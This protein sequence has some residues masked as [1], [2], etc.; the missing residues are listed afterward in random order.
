MKT[1]WI[2]PSLIAAGAVAALA[3]CAA[4]KPA[5]MSWVGAARGVATS[6][7]PKLLAVLQAEIAR[8]GPEGA[9]AACRDQAPALARG[10]GRFDRQLHFALERLS[11]EEHLEGG[12][13]CPDPA[14]RPAVYAADLAPVAADR[15]LV[16][17]IEKP[18]VG[19]PLR[20]NRRELGRWT[21]F[22]E[23]KPRRRKFYQPPGEERSLMLEHEVPVARRGTLGGDVVTQ[24]NE[25]RHDRHD[26]RPAATDL[27]SPS[28]TRPTGRGFRACRAGRFRPSLCCSRLARSPGPCRAA[29]R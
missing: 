8:G 2:N 6:V 3:G 21:T 19:K 27:P 7:P 18:V 23:R 15:P 17:E 25:S 11:H 14:E 20:R 24:E 10:G 28:P 26:S 5:D 29:R 22:E 4:P 13:C 1:R 9:I 12:V 16:V